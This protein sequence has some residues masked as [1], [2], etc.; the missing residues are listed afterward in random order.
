MWCIKD[1]IFPDKSFQSRLKLTGLFSVSIVLLLYWGIGFLMMSGI[2]DNNPS[3][4]RIFFCIFIY[5]VGLSLMLCAD[6]Q[7]FI[8]LKYR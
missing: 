6:L 4:E 5:V 3:P 2:A 8:T 7:K 1:Y